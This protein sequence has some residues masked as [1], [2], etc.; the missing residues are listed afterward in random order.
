[1]V[2][3]LKESATALTAIVKPSGG[4]YVIACPKLDLA[5]E[6]DTP[7]AAFEDL[8]DMALNY[9]AQY[10]EKYDLFSM[11]PNRAAHAPFVKVVHEMESREKVKALFTIPSPF[12]SATTACTEQAAYCG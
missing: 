7:E 6:G 4:K 12:S 11:S 10:I 8:I 1:M 9:A 2:I 5:T 3:I